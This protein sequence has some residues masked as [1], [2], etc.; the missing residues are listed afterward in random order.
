MTVLMTCLR[1]YGTR[2]GLN[3]ARRQRVERTHNM[4]TLTKAQFLGQFRAMARLH[5]S[6]RCKARAEA[7]K[8]A[9][10][11]KGFSRCEDCKAEKPNRFK[12]TYKS[13]KKIGKTYQRN[14]FEV[15]HIVPAGGFDSL[16]EYGQWLTRLWLDDPTGYR[17]LCKACHAK[18]TREQKK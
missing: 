13:G 2:R 7:R 4:G 9:R 17:T 1:S 14:E 8:R 3:V 12:D 16:I 10:T 15:D 6:Q 11:R 5:W 18:K